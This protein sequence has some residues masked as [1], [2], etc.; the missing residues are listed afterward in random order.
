VFKHLKATFPS[1][2]SGVQASKLPVMFY[3]KMSVHVFEV[4]ES[5]IEDMVTDKQFD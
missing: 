4:V 2:H 1:V 5:K 3:N